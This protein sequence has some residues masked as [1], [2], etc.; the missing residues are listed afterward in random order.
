MPYWEKLNDSKGSKNPAHDLQLDIQE[1]AANLAMQFGSRSDESAQAALGMLSNATG[2][3]FSAAGKGAKMKVT[4][5]AKALDVLKNHLGNKGKNVRYYAAGDK[6]E[7]PPELE[8]LSAKILGPPPKG[9]EAFLKLEDLTKKVGQYFEATTETGERTRTLIPF[10][11]HWV[12]KKLS[13]KN[14]P[15][16]DQRGLP[17]D[18]RNIRDIVTKS[19]PDML[20]AAAE[21]I[22]DF[23]NNQSLVVLFT[24]GGK[25]LLFVGDAQA[26]NWEYWLY[27]IDA[28]VSDPT[29]A[30]MTAVSKKILKSIDF[31]KV[32]HHGSTNATP[33][34]V[35]E[36]LTRGQAGKG[37]VAMCSTQPNTYGSSINKSEVPRVPLMQA[38][39]KECTLVRSDSLA[40][41]V[42]KKS[43]RVGVKAPLRQPKVGKLIKKG[44]YIEYSF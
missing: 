28:P 24:F 14:Y 39:N 4:P 42:G 2:V 3:D 27:K 15:K 11:S 33:I 7:L 44:L 43:I 9:S 37:F 29:G 40:I 21:K 41:K 26:G 8:G 13:P 32:G 12:I 23:L 18:Y 30:T 16:K 6:P 36:A 35:V 1:L 34:A 22:D 5:N 25:K 19:Q 20:A 17:I 38:L 10:Q 31:Y